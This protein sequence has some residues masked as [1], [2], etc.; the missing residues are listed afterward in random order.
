MDVVH[1]P[2]ETFKEA[3]KG[4]KARMLAYD[5]LCHLHKP[6]YNLEIGTGE[7]FRAK[8]MDREKH[9]SVCS[10]LQKGAKCQVCAKGALMVSKIHLGEDITFDSTYYAHIDADDADLILSDY[11]SAEVAD[12]I[13]SLFEATIMG[14]HA[15]LSSREVDIFEEYIWSLEEDFPNKSKE[16]VALE[17]IMRNFLFNG[18]IDLR[19]HPHPDNNINMDKE[20]YCIGFEDEKNSINLLKKKRAKTEAVEVI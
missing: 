18:K 4:E 7:Y 11:F 12:N 2:N 20:K 13:E 5:V 10:V 6:V 15:T 19:K 8:D 14:N 1:I 3:P 17:Q 16:E 9:A